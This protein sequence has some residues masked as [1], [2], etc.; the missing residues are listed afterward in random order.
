MCLSH[1]S[2]LF[3]KSE[4]SSAL[5][6]TL[7]VNANSS[8]CIA[9][10]QYASDVGL[11]TAFIT[12]VVVFSV[13]LILF[14]ICKHLPWFKDRYARNKDVV[15]QRPGVFGWLVSTWMV[16]VEE[17]T[18]KRGLDYSV[19]LELVK[20]MF[21]CCCGYLVFG[22]AVLVPTHYFAGGQKKIQHF[23]LDLFC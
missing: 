4:N 22:F 11:L 2:F 8:Y 20:H 21:F 1:L 16:P 9:Q 17:I 15:A 12:N 14:L 5:N 23:V 19:H 3:L 7:E 10:S 18:L 13:F 6:C